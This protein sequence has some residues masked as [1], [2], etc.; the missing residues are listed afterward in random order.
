M[1]KVENYYNSLSA[2]NSHP[3]KVRQKCIKKFFWGESAYF[4][5]E[6]NVNQRN[7]MQNTIYAFLTLINGNFV[8]EF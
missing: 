4:H 2:Y 1:S 5:G 7:S 8:I 3:D 6:L